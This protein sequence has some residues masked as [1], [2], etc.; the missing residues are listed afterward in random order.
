MVLKY[1]RLLSMCCSYLYSLNIPYYF[2]HY[3][4]K[5]GGF[6][7]YAS[8]PLFLSEIQLFL[9][10][11]ALSSFSRAYVL[12]LSDADVCLSIYLSGDYSQC[13]DLHPYQ[14]SQKE[15]VEV[16]FL[17]CLV[18]PILLVIHTLPF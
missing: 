10:I 15:I 12:L 2:F 6:E 3:Q 17:F 7:I 8:L 11:L 14:S 9:P 18:F 1:S 4:S 5:G 16:M 13:R